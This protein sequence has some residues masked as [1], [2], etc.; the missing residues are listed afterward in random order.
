M[1]ERGGCGKIRT[2]PRKGLPSVPFDV[3]RTWRQRPHLTRVED[4]SVAKKNVTNRRRRVRLP[5]VSQTFGKL[6][7]PL[8]WARPDDVLIC[9]KDVFSNLKSK[10]LHFVF[11]TYGKL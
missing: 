11:L 1:T 3:T 7:K 5:N 9:V 10:R 6:K 4:V 2:N 8:E